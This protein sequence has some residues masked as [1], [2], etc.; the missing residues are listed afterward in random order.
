MRESVVLE[1]LLCNMKPAPTMYA[2]KKVRYVE[3]AP[4]KFGPFTVLK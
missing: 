3:K 1:R 2:V 4:Q